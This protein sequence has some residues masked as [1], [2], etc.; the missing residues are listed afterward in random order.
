MIENRPLRILLCHSS[1]DNSIARE[2][3]HQLDSE[4]WMDVWFIEARLLPSQNW[5]PEIIKGVESADVVI[6]LLSKSSYMKEETDYPNLDFVFDALQDSDNK[7]VFVIPLLLGDDDLPVRLKAWQSIDYFPKN[8]RKLIYQKMLLSLRDYAQRL[9]LSLDKRLPHPAPEKS[10]QWTPWLWKKLDGEDFE[11]ETE[12]KPPVS[13]VTRSRQRLR[14]K[15]FSGV[16]NLFVWAAAIGTLLVISVCGLT[17]NYLVRGGDTNSFTVP[18]I[19]RALTFVPLPTPTLGVG[20]VRISP[21]DGMRM[22]YVPAGEFIMGNNDGADDEKPARSV[23]LDAFWIDQFEVTNEM[24]KMCVDAGRCIPPDYGIAREQISGELIPLV[25]PKIIFYAD[26][27]FGNY[28]VSNVTW[29]D[30][31]AYCTWAER[32]LPTEAEWEKAARGVDGR[33]YP[34]GENLDCSKANVY[35]FPADKTCAYAPTRVGSYE[36]GVSPFGVYDMAGNVTEFVSD[37]YDYVERSEAVA[38][39]GI[40]SRD[41]RVLKGGSWLAPGYVA[42]SANRE[43]WDI[44]FGNFD[45]PLANGFRCATSSAVTV[46]Q[47][48]LTP[49]PPRKNI[50]QVSQIDGMPMMYVPAGEFVMGSDYF[51][52]DEKPAHTVYLDAFWIDQHEVTNGMY[53]KCVEAKVCGLPMPEDMSWTFSS[54]ASEEFTLYG[55]RD[56]KFFE[57]LANDTEFSD[58][59]VTHIWWEYANAYCSWAGRRLPTEAEWEKAARGVDGRTYPWGEQVSCLKAN[60]FSCVGA[61]LRVGSLEAGQSPYGAYDMAGNAM[62]WVTDWYSSAYYQNSPYENPLGPGAGLYRVFR[63]G[64]W[65]NQESSARSTNRPGNLANVPIEYI[66]FRCASS[67]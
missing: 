38:P 36:N 59:P 12:S 65:N 10:M 44:I 7:Q 54:S 35:A 46:T 13:D 2:L 61:P 1:R 67:E 56:S 24:Y 23:D 39:I 49:V 29:D 25:K 5:G 6:A 42:R 55:P 3:Y 16:N 22:V 15:L 41:S 14:M 51:E 40:F 50:S 43:R 26:T 9:G 57:Q 66:G 45:Y 19:S 8:R 4:G 58:Q 28:P 62:E 31:A 21:V 11:V 53:A 30:A 33:T 20:S 27:E 32:R 37:F 47:T 60:F 64:S 18:I 52:K 48:D 17:I 63:G 34:W